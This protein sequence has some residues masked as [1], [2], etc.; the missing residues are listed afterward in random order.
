MRDQQRNHPA[1]QRLARVARALGP[2]AREVVFI[3]GAVAP[4]LQT[5]PPFAAPRPTRDVD[6]LIGTRS[7]GEAERFRQELRA[8]G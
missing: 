1:V 4:L 7:Y 3:G 8:L 6:A 2:L 5:A